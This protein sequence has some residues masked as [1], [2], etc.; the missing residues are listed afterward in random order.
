MRPS[1]VRHPRIAYRRARL[2]PAWVRNTDRVVGHWINANAP[3]RNRDGILRSL[4]RSADRGRLWIAIAVLLIALGRSRAAVRGVASLTVASILANLVGKK[5][6]G[7]PRPL[8]KDIPFG[9]RVARYPTSASFPSGHSASAA[10]FATGVALESP[11]AGAVIGPLAVAVAYSRLHV[12]AHWLSDVVGGVTL[13]SSVAIAGSLI[14]PARIPDDQPMPGSGR[15]V[16]LPASPDGEGVFLV[17]NPKAGK[18]VVRADPRPLLSRRLPRA[19]IHEL[20][21]NETPAD[22]VRVAM[23]AKNP[24]AVLAV[25]GG[26]GSV[27]RMA[28]LARRY[29]RPLLVLPGGTFNHFARAVGVRSVDDGIDALRS[30]SALSVSVGDVGLGEQVFTMLNA[31]S[32]GIYPEFL[33]ERKRWKKRYGKWLAGLIA[34]K[35]VLREAEPVDIEVNGRPMRV[36]SL[37]VSVGR[38]DPEQIATMQRRSLD[39]DTLDV[40]ILPARGPRFRAVASMAFGRRTA[41]ILR[42]LRLLPSRTDVES[43]TAERLEV[44]VKGGGGRPVGLAHDGE[45]ERPERSYTAVLSASAGALSVYAPRPQ[46]KH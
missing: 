28:S 22:A 18:D 44:R 33:T 37:F 39:D 23:E 7:G 34:A 42:A 10:A 16:D 32:V 1:R 35:R 8:L 11:A 24:A 29:D 4:S 21:P 9:R 20:E 3:Q 13:G 46:E 15:S 38:N 36:W 43:F 31:G 45:L 5:L 19:V 6:F 14:A 2:L 17:M 27:S 12:G 41:R 25:Y 30:G 40:R 26:D